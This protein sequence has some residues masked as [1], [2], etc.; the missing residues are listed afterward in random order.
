[1]GAEAQNTAAALS[2]SL[3]KVATSRKHCKSSDQRAIESRKSLG[4]PAACS[5]TSHTPC[6]GE[7]PQ[8]HHANVCTTNRQPRRHRRCVHH[9][10]QA[11]IKI[12]CYRC[13]LVQITPIVHEYYRVPNVFGRGR[14]NSM[15]IA[16]FCEHAYRGVVWWKVHTC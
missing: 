1:M 14:E 4:S 3:A 11:A 8:G 12:P 2:T 9:F 16:I 5:M 15:P 6:L 10:D 7:P 13:A